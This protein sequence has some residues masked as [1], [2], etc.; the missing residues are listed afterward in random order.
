M[1][2]HPEIEEL[3]DYR[4]ELLSPE[5]HGEIRAH[6]RECSACR[7]DLAAIRD[8]MDDLAA[9]PVEAEPS[10]DLWPQIQWRIGAGSA[11]EEARPRRTAVTLPVWQ[12]LAASVVLAL[13]SGGAV[14]AYLAGTVQGPGA[15][16]MEPAPRTVPAGAAAEYAA[17]EGFTDAVAELETV[18]E[19]GRD[20]LG[21][22]T[23]QVL[24]EN[25][26]IIDRAILDSRLALAQD[27]GSRT[28][29]RLLSQTMRR[30]VDL[31]Q[32]AAEVIITN[33]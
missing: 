2:R 28:L 15:V 3:Q 23:I 30:K 26:A 5:R 4:E 10:R 22:E 24:E 18:V 8:L 14:W 21:P 32:Q 16:V 33:S 20:L 7:E 11:R 17:Y 13:I 31:L 27:P 1:N 12:L 9:L 19:E 25:L 6:L 29:R